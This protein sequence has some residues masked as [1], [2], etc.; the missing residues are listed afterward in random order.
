M[1]VHPLVKTAPIAV[2][3]AL[4]TMLPEPSSAPSARPRPG[5]HPQ[6]V[7]RCPAGTLLEPFPAASARPLCLPRPTTRIGRLGPAAQRRLAGNNRLRLR[8]LSE[9]NKI[10]RFPERE[11]EYGLY[12][13]PLQP[14]I[15]IHPGHSDGDATRQRPGVLIEGEASAPV[16]LVTLEGEMEQPHVLLVGE[17][18]GKTVVVQHRLRTKNG[19]R[20]YLAIYGNLDRPGPGIVNGATLSPLS[21]I[22]FLSPQPPQDSFSHLYF[23]LRR[24]R[25]DWNKSTTPKSL[26]RAGTSTPE[27]PRNVLRLRADSAAG[28]P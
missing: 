22:G 21:V 4:L 24:L 8:L 12:V 25:Q 14:A 6:N 15:G 27:D 9:Q 13:L 26:L 23:E 28:R 17:L 11:A 5:A 1:P 18:Y 20:D 19:Y 7:S 2:L 16:T 3:F 10:A